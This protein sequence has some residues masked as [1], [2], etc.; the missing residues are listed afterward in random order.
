MKN[1]VGR[2]FISP[3]LNIIQAILYKSFST[4]AE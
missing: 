3:T 2:I 4:K 1:S